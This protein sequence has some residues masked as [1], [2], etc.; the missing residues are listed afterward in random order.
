[1]IIRTWLTSIVYLII[2]GLVIRTFLAPKSSSIPER[3][4]RA[5]QTSRISIF[6]LALAC[7][8]VEHIIF[9]TFD[10]LT[11]FSCLVIMISDITVYR[12]FLTS[13]ASCIIVLTLL[14]KGY[15]FSC[16]VI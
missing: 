3:L 12:R 1:M 4:V 8:R 13:V 5:T 9:R 15:A 2:D 16:R 14:T 6:I 11:L 10:G 7:F